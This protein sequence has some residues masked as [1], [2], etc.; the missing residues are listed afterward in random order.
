MRPSTNSSIL[1]AFVKKCGAQLAS[2]TAMGPQAKTI[3]HPWLRTSAFLEVLLRL[4]HKFSFIFC[5]P[6]SIIQMFPKVLLNYANCGMYYMS[7]IRTGVGK[8]FSRR[9]ALTI[10]E[11][12]RA[13][14]LKTLQCLHTRACSSLRS[15]EDLLTTLTCRIT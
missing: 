2:V 13:C 9:A 8:L 10:Q 15:C 11:W 14:V 3:A 7:L 1:N 6:V 4:S 12:L 5:F